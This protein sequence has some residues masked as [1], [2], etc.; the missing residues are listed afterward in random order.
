ME[1]NPSNAIRRRQMPHAFKAKMEWFA[2]GFHQPKSKREIS[3]T[4]IDSSQDMI[5]DKP[6]D[7][8]LPT[9]GNFFSI[10]SY[11]FA[12]ERR[13]TNFTLIRKKGH[14]G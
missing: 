13:Q 5:W 8:L 2:K 6:F 4:T 1:M 3:A 7:D 9:Y 14:K 10:W 12:L 11:I